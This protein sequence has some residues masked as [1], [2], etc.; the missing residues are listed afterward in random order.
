MA[1]PTG[2]IVPVRGARGAVLWQARRAG[3]TIAGMRQF[4]AEKGLSMRRFSRRA[5]LEMTTASAA[6]AASRVVRATEP[7]PASGDGKKTRIALMGLNSRGKQ[8]LRPFLE[9]PEVEI[10][11][12]CDP[13]SSV[14]AP[15]LKLVKDRAKNEPKVVSDFRKALDDRSVDVLVCAAPDHWHAL[16]TIL[17]CQSGKDVYVE[18]PC[19]H[20]LVEGRRMIQAAR[21]HQRVVQVGTQRRSAEDLIAAVARVRAGRLGK[22]HL[23]RAWITSVRRSPRVTRFRPVGRPGDESALSEESRSLPLALALALRHGRVR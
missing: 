11:Y 19:S 15:A 5:F 17:A 7:S 3:A 4:P 13:D 14:I 6:V 18:K 21:A 12:L 9:F 16:A 23:A 22:V 1:R 20:N 10:A 2:T 8:L